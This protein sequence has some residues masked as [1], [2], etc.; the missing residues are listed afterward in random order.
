MSEKRYL[1]IDVCRH[2]E[3]H[4]LTSE[5]V[6]ECWCP[7]MAGQNSL[8]FGRAIGNVE[9]PDWCPLPTLTDL[10][11]PLRKKV[12]GALEFQRGIVERGV[13]FK[14][15]GY[16]EGLD[17]VLELLNSFCNGTLEVEK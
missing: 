8:G 4:F 2:C 9:M 5:G 11:S 15:A 3:N 6:M 14:E 7:V 1:E 10:L 13:D 16:L 12:E 17:D